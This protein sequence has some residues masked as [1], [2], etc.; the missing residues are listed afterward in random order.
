MAEVDPQRTEVEPLDPE[1]EQ[2]IDGPVSAEAVRETRL[3][4]ADA[5][6]GM[7]IRLPERGNRKLAACSTASTPTRS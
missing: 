6:A 1:I 2:R 4:P 3:S 7:R 5:V